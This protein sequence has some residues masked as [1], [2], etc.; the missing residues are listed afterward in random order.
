MRQL[1]ENEK[2]QLMEQGNVAEDWNLV[3]IA[4]DCE[5]SVIRNNM[6]IGQVRL[7][8][9]SHN[10]VSDGTVHLPEGV[11]N[12]MISNANIGNHCALHNV[13]MLQGYTI[14]DSCI[15]FNINEMTSGDNPSW[16][17]PMNENGG[18][19]IMPFAGMTIADAYLWAKYRD[20][21]KMVDRLE[22]MTREAIDSAEGTYGQVGP[23]C[24]LKNCQAI[25]NVAVLSDKDCPTRI[26]NC[27]ALTD[28]VVGYGCHLEHGCIATRFV[29]GEN[30]KLEYGV[31]LNDTVVGDN[32]TIARCE[33]GNNIIF[34]AHEQHHNN[35]F[36]IAS[37]VMG[38]SNVAAGCTIGSNHNGR[39]AD[40]ELVAGRGFWP[41]LCTSLKHSSTFASYTLL[42]KGDYPSELSI[43]LPFSLVNNNVA[44]NRL[45]VMPAYWWMYNM[46]ALNRNITKFAKRDKRVKKTQHIVFTPFAPD[47]AE[48]II[49]GRMLL[50]Y[51][52]EQAYYQNDGK[53]P[54]EVVGFG[55][56]KGKRKTV[57]A[58]WAQGFKAYEDMLIYYAM[59]TLTNNG[60]INSLPENTLAKGER[61]RE[62]VNLG[63]QLVPQCEI[64]RLIHDIECGKINQWNEI[65]DRYNQWWEAY[66]QWCQ[67]HAYQVLCHLNNIG[68]I[69][70]AH[71][72][73]LLQRYSTIQKYVA[74]QVRIT[75]QKDDANPFRQMT[76]RNDAEMKAVLG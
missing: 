37:L 34:P 45:E 66:P 28:G 58:K 44:K 50:K 64:D 63:G 68:E 52:V 73:Q 53:E 8:L 74:D 46:Y 24:T 5:L 47:T 42:A 70:E 56:E 60:N 54:M 55:L 20:H 27:V 19:R 41:G 22:Q 59:D 67:K 43:T 29:L 11:Y 9:M 16:L 61:E 39:T 36:L 32:S 6:F 7:G 33:V 4:D 72:Q 49:N 14:G 3:T 51:W 76:Y 75:R 18:R 40:N 1:T 38:Q 10:F 48:E 23:Y 25:H 26:E 65:H 21:S 62:W 69:S 12:S 57:I 15:L 17:E 2:L 13:R 30:V 35:S 71:W 31:R